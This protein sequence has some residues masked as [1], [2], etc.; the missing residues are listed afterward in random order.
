MA[1]PMILSIFPVSTILVA[2]MYVCVCV[3][4]CACVCVC[5][6]VG[7]C[8]C[9]NLRLRGEPG[10]LILRNLDVLLHRD[11]VAARPATIH[12]YMT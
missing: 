1:N 6:C 2:Y 8:V 12:S 9:V 11:T 10:R 5:V 3:C 4:V 7:V